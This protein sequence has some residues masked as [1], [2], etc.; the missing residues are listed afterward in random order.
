MTSATEAADGEAELPA[1]FV[2]VLAAAVLQLDPLQQVPDALVGIQLGRVARQALQVQPLRRARGEELLDRLAVVDGRAVSDH[3]QLA[4]DLAQELTEE[5]DDRWPAEGIWLDVGEEPPVR[6]EG[7]D[8][9]EVVARERRAQ[10]GRLPPWSVR[11]S[12]EG[13]Q[14]EAGLVYEDDRSVLRL[15]FA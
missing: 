5:G 9:S 2:Q 14:V 3:E 1:Q 15:G 4:A 7:A 11:A 8:R 10:N 13:Q 6:G 12:Q